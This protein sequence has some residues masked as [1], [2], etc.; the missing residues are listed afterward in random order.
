MLPNYH[1]DAIA[2]Q[3]D[4]NLSS[5]N[6]D[7]GQFSAEFETEVGQEIYGL[8]TSRIGVA[9]LLGAV[10]SAESRPPVLAIE[11]L[12]SSQVGSGAFDDGMKRLTGRIIRYVIQHLGGDY[13]QRGVKV[14]EGLGSHYKSGST[15]SFASSIRG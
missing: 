8:L 1:L 12:L 10:F 11:P 3:S 7:A 9:L 13:G 4:A 2:L 5:L 14:P 15:Y 6:F